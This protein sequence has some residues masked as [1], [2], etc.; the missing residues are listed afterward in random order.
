MSVFGIEKM[1]SLVVLADHIADQLELK[2]FATPDEATNGA[3]A[4]TIFADSVTTPGQSPLVSKT[5]V[6]RAI[7]VFL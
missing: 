4:G 7:I 5:L 6:L 1:D 3:L 2:A